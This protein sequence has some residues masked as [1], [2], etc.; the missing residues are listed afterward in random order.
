MSRSKIRHHYEGLTNILAKASVWSVRKIMAMVFAVLNKII[1]QKVP[2]L[3][4]LSIFQR[5]L[6]LQGCIC[7][8]PYS[9][10]AGDTLI[11]GTWHYI[12]RDCHPAAIWM[13]NFISYVTLR[14]E[15]NVSKN[16]FWIYA[17]VINDSSYFLTVAFDGYV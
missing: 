4:I 11:F 13:R 16:Q 5:P 2:W 12:W 7:C 15:A 6:I 10:I 9:S 1:F 8:Y 3:R 17:R 14:H